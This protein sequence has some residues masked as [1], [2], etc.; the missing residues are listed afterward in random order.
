MLYF[1]SS[2]RLAK[3]P[4]AR[5]AASDPRTNNTDDI[6]DLAK[7]ESGK[8]NLVMETCSLVDCMREAL[9]MF[10]HASQTKEIKMHLHIDPRCPES[11]NTDKVHEDSARRN[12]KRTHN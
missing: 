1:L 5:V 10:V 4:R 11:I 7:L 2:V 12:S 6:L 3:M 8:V 9:A